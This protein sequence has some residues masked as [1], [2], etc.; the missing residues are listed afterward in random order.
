MTHHQR[1]RAIR[2]SF[3]LRRPE[4]APERR[5]TGAVLSALISGI[6][7]GQASYRDTAHYYGGGFGRA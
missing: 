5:Q 7:A 1:M 4:P 3:A 2:E 6:K